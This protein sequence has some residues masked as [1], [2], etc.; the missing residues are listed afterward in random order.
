MSFDESEDLSSPVDGV[1]DDAEHLLNIFPLGLEWSRFSNLQ[2]R[3]EIA[4]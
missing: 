3:I 4:R 2:R 1:A